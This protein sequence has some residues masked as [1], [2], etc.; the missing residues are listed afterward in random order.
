M[1]E[2]MKVSEFI[3]KLNLALNSK[4]LYVMGCFG[5]PMITKNKKRYSSNYAYNA[6]DARKNKILS[7][8]D[9]TFGFDCVN[10]VK[11]VIN[12]W[13]ADK[14]AI[15]GGT[16]YNAVVPDIG[17]ESIIKQ[18]TDV[19]T[20]FSK[21]T[22]GELLY[23]K[24]HVGVVYDAKNGLAVECTPAWK[25]GVQISAINGADWSSG[26]AL[27]YHTRTWTSHG[28]L[29]WIDY[30]V[31]PTEEFLYRVQVGVYKKEAN[32]RA[33]LKELQDAGFKNAII[34]KESLNES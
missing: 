27:K 30:T 11:G 17:T 23:T 16:I 1:S 34:R 28:K 9:D 24:G 33:K 25:D 8:S 3:S 5:A 29:P 6:T 22:D 4:T 32:A 18:C 21:L 31:E 13:S 19:S 2:K 12:G 7:A 14:T 10:L 26:E 20:D 15:Y